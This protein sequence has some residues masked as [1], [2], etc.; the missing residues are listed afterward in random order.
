MKRVA[1]DFFIT[2]MREST[3]NMERPAALRIIERYGNMP[4]LVLISCILS[5]RTKDTVSYP[6]SCRLFDLAKTPQ[7]MIQLKIDTIEQSIYSVG[8]YRQKAKQIF[9][10]SLLLLEKY[11]G[12]VPCTLEQLLLLPGVG[13]K[14]A[15]LVLG[16]SFGIPAI[17]VDVHV[18]RIAN[19]WG[20]VATKTPFE[21][22]E[23]LMRIVDKK[24]WIELNTLMVM[25]GQNICLPINPR[26]SLCPLQSM[27]AKIGVL[28]K[29]N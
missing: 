13:R 14:T 10:L 22:E 12:C 27:C 17:C 11:D 25:W 5:L 3:K 23:A 15:N 9:A 29:K 2:T 16:Y 19:R 28:T 18:H 8:F 7:E 4:Y 26:C 6:A 21:T 1:V 20:I 24:Y